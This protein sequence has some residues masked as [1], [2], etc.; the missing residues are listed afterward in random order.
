MRFMEVLTKLVVGMGRFGDHLL[1]K[2]FSGV[3]VA[4]LAFACGAGLV[5]ALKPAPQA[6]HR[7]T[8]YVAAPPCA[9]P[10]PDA[11]ADYDEEEWDTPELEDWKNRHAGTPLRLDYDSMPNWAKLSVSKVVALPSGR[12][13]AAAGDALYML[14]AD[15]RAVWKLEVPQ[16]VID[17]A[18]VKATGVIYVTAGDNNLFILD[19]ATGRVLHN[20]SPNG[21]AGFG[22]AIPY[23]DD[24][25]L[26]TKDFGGYRADYRGIETT[27]A[28]TQDAVTAW[29]GT[30]M[31][32]RAE[33]PPD[34]ELQVV[35]SKIFAVTKTRSNILVKEIKP[36]KGER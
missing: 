24:V 31:L 34:A 7:E 3:V 15:R 26:V 33:V 35:G 28:P 17:F 27:V 6:G 4:A 18:Y 22:A 1:K 19:A 14:G 32:W 10:T 12:T 29:R 11:A 21:R 25:C 30:R 13:L 8:R 2:K 23:G 9:L 16:T 36:P 20:E 5:Y